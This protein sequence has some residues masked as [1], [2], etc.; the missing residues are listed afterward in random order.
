MVEL[1]YTGDLKFPAVRYEGSTPSL[2]TTK[3]SHRDVFCYNVFMTSKYFRLLLPAIFGIIA[4]VVSTYPWEL[5][6]LPCIIVWGII[7]AIVGFLFTQDGVLKPGI[8]YGFFLTFAF[9]LSRFGGTFNKLPSYL[10][11][12][13]LACIGGIP[14]G[15]LVVWIGS[16]IKQFSHKSQ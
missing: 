3:T 10:V 14:G 5:K 6:F 11:F 12:V 2:G 1:V 15:L 13:L 8:T 7:G 16:K 4:G 9:L